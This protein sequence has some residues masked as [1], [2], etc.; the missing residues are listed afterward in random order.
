MS[1]VLPS[2]LI[3]FVLLTCGCPEAWAAGKTTE[4]DPERNWELKPEIKYFFASDTAYQ[5]GDMNVE[6]ADK[7]LSRLEFPLNTI[8]LGGELRR[9][10]P[11]C[12]IGLNALTSVARNTFGRFKDS[13]WTN[14][15]D[16]DERTIFSTASCR[17]EYGIMLGGDIDL[18]VNDWL[19]LPRYL[20]LRPLI[21]IQWQEFSFMAHD[22]LQYEYNPPEPE[23]PLPGD[24]LHFKQDY[25]QYLIGLRGSWDMGRPFN[26]P[27]LKALSEVH[28]SYVTASNEDQHLL[29]RGLRFTFE[30]TV[31][32]GFYVSTGLKATLTKN[33]TV[34]A[35]IDYLIMRT[36]GTH[37][38]YHELYEVD[39]T[40]SKA[41]KVWSDQVGVKLDVTYVF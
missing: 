26:L 41:V 31:G 29:R 27:P 24:T 37:R 36:T 30:D 33:I 4:I 19:K 13:D 18:K 35:S 10:F 40:W 38:W 16:P 8:W 7:P 17:L 15:D 9:N 14:P 2:A 6:P 28:W 21:G 11:R 1:K 5:F 20:D 3:L 22:G 32:W 34:G 23:I 39:E 12:S 25:W